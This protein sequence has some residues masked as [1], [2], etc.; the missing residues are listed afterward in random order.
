MVPYA[1]RD[2]TLESSCEKIQ[3]S[4]CQGQTAVLARA[5]VSVRRTM[6]VYSASWPLHGLLE[7]GWRACHTSHCSIFLLLDSGQSC[8]D[9]GGAS[10]GIDKLTVL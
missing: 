10:T 4:R 6:L 9:Y 2:W 5:A 8:R 7:D 1:C 3:D